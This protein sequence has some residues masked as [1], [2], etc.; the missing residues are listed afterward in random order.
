[1]QTA[2]GL[3][4]QMYSSDSLLAGDAVTKTKSQ[5]FH[6]VDQIRL[7]ERIPEPHRGMRC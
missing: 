3:E 6:F 4:V 2:C 5:Y 7:N 1:M